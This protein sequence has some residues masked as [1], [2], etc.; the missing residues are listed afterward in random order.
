MN[1][2]QTRDLERVNNIIGEVMGTLGVKYGRGGGFENHLIPNGTYA[3]YFKGAKKGQ[4]QRLKR[5]NDGKLF[6]TDEL[7]D[8]LS[9]RYEIFTEAGVTSVWERVTP[10]IGS[11]AKLRKH[12]D[13]LSHGAFARM[14]DT[15]FA[16]KSISDD[17]IAAKVDAFIEKQIDK[18]ASVTVNQWTGQKDG[19]T[20][21]G[22]IDIG[23]I[24]QGMQVAAPPK[25]EEETSASDNDLFAGM[26]DP[27]AP[28]DDDDIPF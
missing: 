7:E 6:K 10:S 8:I 28:V 21:N 18:T 15:L 23:A 24:P 16:D 27:D 9:L 12:M 11:R 13:A 1:S 17:E 25:E 3:A 4:R 5:S 19:V 22:F 20:R 2:R 14:V 26:V